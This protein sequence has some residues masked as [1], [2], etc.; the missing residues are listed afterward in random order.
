[1]SPIG[2]FKPVATFNVPGATTAEIVSATPDGRTLL[3]N[4]IAIIDMSHPASPVLE[5]IFSAGVVDDRP[6]DLLD[7]STISF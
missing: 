3:Y 4:G 1:L 2:S 6:A 5:S 7:D